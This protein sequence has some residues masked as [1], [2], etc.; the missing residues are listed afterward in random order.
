MMMVR[1]KALLHEVWFR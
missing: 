1:T